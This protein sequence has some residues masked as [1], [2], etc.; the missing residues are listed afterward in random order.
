MLRRYGVR[1][2]SAVGH[3]QR[4]HCHSGMGREDRAYKLWEAMDVLMPHDPFHVQHA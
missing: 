1:H 2:D 3:K 4:A